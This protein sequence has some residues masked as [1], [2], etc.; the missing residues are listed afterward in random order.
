MDFTVRRD[1]ETHAER[2]TP[3]ATHLS[4]D[5]QGS[6]T[7][8]TDG[9]NA[10]TDYFTTHPDQM[11]AGFVLTGGLPIPKWGPTDALAIQILEAKQVGESAGNELGYGALARRLK[12]HN[13]INDAV[14]VLNDLQF[15]E[16][17]LTPVSVP[18]NQPAALTTDG[19]H[20]DYINYTPADTAARIN[21]SPSR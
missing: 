14:G 8:F 17:P 20:H 7:R 2:K 5:Q 11:P 1:S 9:I 15:T 13:G 10:Y 21:R 4:A 12:N 19:L 16:D 3:I 18:H 6:L